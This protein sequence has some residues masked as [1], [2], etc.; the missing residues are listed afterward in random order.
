[1]ILRS[2]EPS[3]NEIYEAAIVNNCKVNI[4]DKND[5]IIKIEYS[6]SDNKIA[7]ITLYFDDRGLV[8]SESYNGVKEVFLES[9]EEVCYYEHTPSYKEGFFIKDG[10]PFYFKKWP[11]E[12]IIILYQIYKPVPI[13]E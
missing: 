5:K 8:V 12:N 2:E 6:S 3:L 1:M 9:T 13:M 11:M 10:Y 4:T 7:Y